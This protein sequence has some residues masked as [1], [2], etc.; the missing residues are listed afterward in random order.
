MK[1]VLRRLLKQIVP[2]FAVERARFFG[3]DAWAAAGWGLSF[4]PGHLPP[5]ALVLSEPDAQIFF[6]YY[7]ISP[8]SSNDRR[9]LAQRAPAENVS[10]HG[11][12]HP[13]LDLGF[14]DLAGEDGAKKSEKSGRGKTDAKP[15]F[16]AFAQSRCWNWQQ[17]ARLQWVPGGGGGVEENGRRALYNTMLGEAYGAVMCDVESGRVEREIPFPVYSLSPDGERA[18]SLNFSR[19]HRMRPGYGYSNLPDRTEGC[20][21]PEDDGVFLGEI[22]SGR[23]DLV[24]S[25]AQAVAFEPRESMAGAQHYFNHLSFSPSGARWMVTHLWSGGR[26]RSGRKKASR[27][28][29]SGKNGGFSC[30][31]NE[32]FTSH[33]CWKDDDSIIVFGRARE[34]EPMGYFL[35]DLES[36]ARG[37]LGVGLLTEDGHQT[38]LRCGRMLTDTYP[39][40]LRFQRVLLFSPQD[41]ALSV[42]GRFY[43]PPGFSGEV[44]CDLHP[45]V[46]HAQNRVCVDAVFHGRRGLCVFPIRD[47]IRD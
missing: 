42:P 41:Q 5:G 17:G 37:A 38:W 13:P 44:R 28:L 34:G 25:V 8:F 6:G 1:G 26:G 35:H 32:G 23:T 21:A 46:N 30:I 4:L 3:K 27:I 10:P 20:A 18:L 9:I 24:L 43:T 40:R 29:V 22:E 11:G 14:Y 16:H 31:N 19:L 33:Y 7:D 47:H 39:D 45:R 36:G 15:R 12:S 2:R